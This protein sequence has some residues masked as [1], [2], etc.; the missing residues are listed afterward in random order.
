MEEKKVN[1]GGEGRNE[2]RRGWRELSDGR[3]KDGGKVKD[4]GKGGELR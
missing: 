1:Q 3:R 4:G 2:G